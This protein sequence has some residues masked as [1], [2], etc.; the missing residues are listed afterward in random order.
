[1]AIND[2]DTIV[3]FCNIW[4]IYYTFDILNLKK[5]KNKKYIFYLGALIALG[6]GVRFA[7][8]STLLPLVIFVTYVIYKEFNKK[9]LSSIFRF[10]KSYYNII[11]FNCAILDP[12]HENIFSNLMN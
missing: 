12:T 5:I 3:T 2:R 1:M 4:A 8:I 11:F 10:T 9:F 7:F 6:T